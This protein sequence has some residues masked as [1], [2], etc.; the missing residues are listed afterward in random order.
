M[1]R[2]RTFGRIRKRPSGRFQAGYVGP[3]TA[4]HYA[5]V[6]FSAAVDAEGWLRDERRLIESDEWTPPAERKLAKST[7]ASAG[8]T[9]EDYA[10]AWIPA[11]RV[12]GEPLRARTRAE[13]ERLLEVEL[14]PTF[15]ERPL[16]AIRKEEVQRWHDAKADAPTQRARAYGLMRA[17][18]NSAV[19]AELISKSP[20][21]IKGAGRSE[22]VKDIEPATLDELAII[23][24]NT[25]PE[26]RLAIWLAAWCALRFGEVAELRRYDI[27]LKNMRIN[28]RRG[29]VNINGER[30][31][32][33]TKGKAAR[34]VSIPPHLKP[35]IEQHLQDYAQPGRTGL[36]F[37]GRDGQQLAESTMMGKPSRRRRI[38]GRW[39]NESATGFNKAREAAGRP[40]LRFHDLRHTGAVLAARAGATIAE[41]MARLG[42]TTPAAAMIYQHAAEDRD[43]EIARRLSAMAGGQSDK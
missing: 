25:A 29:V 18:M 31:V 33:T 23:V 11:R 28:V 5:P 14:S 22:R 17:I 3:D 41:L 6:T 39:V 16:G 19:E 42:H 40:D 9:F 32:G 20:C 30:I 4:T 2:R 24:E 37:Y 15:G 36:L 43:A 1:A 12:R 34:K 8:T 21:Q 27:D 38:K 10:A 26:R 7:R 13:Y 35:L